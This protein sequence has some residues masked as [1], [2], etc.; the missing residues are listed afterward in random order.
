MSPKKLCWWFREPH[1][2]AGGMVA[3]LLSAGQKSSPAQVVLDG[4][5]GTSGA[6]SG[7]N[8]TITAGMGLTRGNNLFQSFSQFNLVSGDVATFTGPANIQ[9]IM[10]RVTG[11]SASSINGTIRSGIA[12][13]NFFFINPNGVIFGPNAAVDVSG[14]FAASTANYLKLA[15]GAR[16]VASLDA[17]DSGLSTAPVSAF[18]FLGGNSGSIAVQQ[19]TLSVQDGQTLSLVGGDITIDGGSVQAPQG[20]INV[21]SVLSAGEVPV[22]PTASSVAEFNAA[23]PQQGQINLQNLAQLDASGDGGGRIVIRSGQ[24]AVDNSVIQANTTGST[25]GRGIDVA[26]ANDL[27]LINGGQIKS[28]ST[29]GLGAGGNIVIN[30]QSIRL[31]GGGLIDDNFNPLTEISTATGDLFLGGGTGKGGDIVIQTGSLE[32]VNS[33]Q[34]SSATFGAGNA[35]RINISATSILLDALLTTPTQIS[36]NSQQIEGG[37]NAGDI[38]INTGTLEMQNGATILAASFGS[39]RAGLVNINAQSINLFSGSIITAGTFGSG[40]GGDVQITADSMNINGQ[41][42]LA[43]GQDF[44]TGIQAV[45]TSSDSP[46]PGGNIQINAGSLELEHMGSIFT[47][48]YGLGSG[49]NIEVT[50]GNLTLANGSTIRAEGLDAGQAGKISLRAD[51]DIML[52]N[53]SAV[54]TSAPGSSGGDIS[55]I[56]GSNIKLENS[57]I[58]AQAGLDGGNI[59]VAASRLVYLL[60]SILTGQADSTGSGFGNGGN[61]TIDPS[62]LILN[63]SSLISKSSFGNGGNITIQSDYFFQSQSIIDATAPF[64]LP[65]TVTVTAPNVDLSASLV[66]LPGNLLDAETLLQP[67]CGVRLSGNISSF[68][69]LGSGGL[70][71][72]PGGF[73]P[74][75]VP[76][77]ANDKK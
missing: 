46:A 69:V 44:L 33:A 60:H 36:A 28:L 35:G 72:A 54:S 68:I 24:L 37:G 48:S 1:L 10:S 71:V 31:D 32:L 57:Q 27:T 18:G 6:L 43:D 3:I 59:E 8:Y 73:V 30:A 76:A 39:G 40:N 15:D 17:D 56:A 66:A 47:T 26:V 61:I 70:P 77:G 5:F 19:S 74:S 58:T 42:A 64:G 16:F 25:D 11:G 49:G 34:I 55:V 20:Q 52:M 2:L 23:F 67:D 41:T 63:D 21:V 29:A 12:G 62:F 45:T 22:D 4:K 9:N 13:A 38:F 53:N 50:A 51:Q 7:P 65:G 14:S 75:S